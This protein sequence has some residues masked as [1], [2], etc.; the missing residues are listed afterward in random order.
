[1]LFIPVRDLGSKKWGDLPHHQF[2]KDKK[3]RL[4]ALNRSIMKSVLRLRE[5]YCPV[6]ACIH[7]ID[8]VPTESS[9]DAAPIGAFSSIGELKHHIREVHHSYFCDLCLKHSPKFVCEQTLYSRKDLK[10]HMSQGSTDRKH[11]HP[12]CKFCQRNFYSEDEMFAHMNKDHE[13]CFLCVRSS[14]LHHVYY[15]N[16]AGLEEHFRACHFLCED[17]QCLQMRFVVFPTNLEL[18]SHTV[19]NHMAGRGKVSVAA[20]DLQVSRMNTLDPGAPGN[21]FDLS[22]LAHATPAPSAGSSS[23]SSSNRADAMQRA[24]RQFETQGRRHGEVAAPV[25][26]VQQSVQLRQRFSAAA[27]AF[28]SIGASLVRQADFPELGTSE[29]AH[30]AHAYDDRG[31]DC[32]IPRE[33]GHPAGHLFHE[34]GNCPPCKTLV[35]HPCAGGHCELPTLCHLASSARRK[36][37]A[38]GVPFLGVQKCSRPCGKPLPGCKHL[39]KQPCHAGPCPLPCTA[40]CERIRPDCG[41]SCALRCGHAQN[42]PKAPTDHDPCTIRPCFVKVAASCACG[43]R[44]ETLTCSEL[45]TNGERVHG[46]DGEVPRF[47]LK[48]GKECRNASLRDALG[49]DSHKLVTADIERPPYSEFL[50]TFAQRNNAFVRSVLDKFRAFV[51]DPANPKA[52][53][54]PPMSSEKRLFLHQLASYYFLESE[55]RDA[56]PKRS[57]AMYRTELSSVPPYSLLEAMSTKAE[58]EDHKERTLFLHGITVHSSFPSQPLGYD[59]IRKLDAFLRSRYPGKCFLQTV[60]DEWEANI[61]FTNASSRDDAL[62]KLRSMGFDL[63][64]QPWSRSPVTEVV[65]PAPGLAEIMPVPQ[66]RSCDQSGSD[67][68]HDGWVLVQ[69]GAPA[70]AP[71][72][73]ADKSAASSKSRFAVLASS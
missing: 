37:S 24:R 42:D 3:W 8:Y 54:F 50:K 65:A 2:P 16:Y 59:V 18:H 4:E 41:H 47:R 11:G 64:F 29:Q 19:G 33:C 57:V 12:F 61:L 68:S 22:A 43:V 56:E 55:A 71:A 38:L 15:Q 63:M 52:L 60:Q 44:K 70:E 5:F 30:N 73:D 14:Q 21:P 58:V 36:A 48:C 66:A 13:T 45:R 7:H 28:S 10:V 32:M 31:F 67:K 25:A 1:M 72:S 6:Q 9:Q 27:P 51:M 40:K 17:P 23:S 49:L 20:A 46:V 26:S 34:T 69:N 39:C 62:K 35:S 53:D